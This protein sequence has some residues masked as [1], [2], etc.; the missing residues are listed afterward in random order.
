MH[1]YILYFMYISHCVQY[2]YICVQYMYI[3]VQYIYVYVHMLTQE[4][5]NSFRGWLFLVFK[6]RMEACLDFALNCPSLV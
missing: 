4:C 6:L 3:C 5:G 1:V 2:V